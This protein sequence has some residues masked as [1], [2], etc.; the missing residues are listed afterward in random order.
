MELG[1]YVIGINERNEGAFHS[2]FDVCRV[3]DT[4]HEYS[5]SLIDGEQSNLAVQ[6]MF[7]TSES[8]PV[9]QKL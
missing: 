2:Q 4:E 6:T 3:G 7:Q 1:L 5:N 8:W 9:Y